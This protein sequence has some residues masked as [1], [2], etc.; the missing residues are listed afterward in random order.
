MPYKD[1]DK[2][3]AYNKAYQEANADKIKIQRKG[4]YEANKA[5]I[6]AKHRAYHEANRDKVNTQKKAYYEDNRHERKI[7]RD[8]NVI[9]IR[10]SAVRCRAHKFNREL[11]I[12]YEF[13]ESLADR[14][15]WRCAVTNI[16]FDT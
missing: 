9:A 6:N 11:D 2:K 3:K 7:Y 13:I 4:Y 5:E 14:Q 15:K 1:K 16:K 12:S 8:N 10:F